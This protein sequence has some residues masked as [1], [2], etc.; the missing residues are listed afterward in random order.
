MKNPAKILLIGPGHEIVYL[1]IGPGIFIRSP[2]SN[3][4]ALQ[5]MEKEAIDLILCRRLSPSL[6]LPKEMYPDKAA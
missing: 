3:Q 5:L 1:L 4:K 6:E 2:L